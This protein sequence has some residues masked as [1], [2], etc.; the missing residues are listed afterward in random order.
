MR[1]KRKKPTAVIIKGNPIYIKGNPHAASFYRELADFLRSEGYKVKLDAGEPFTSPPKA[2]L[3]VGHSRGVDRLRFAPKGTITVALG[4]LDGIM[5][6]VDENYQRNIEKLISHFGS[7]EKMRSL[8]EKLAPPKEHY[9]LT[10]EMKRAIK[11]MK[12]RKRNP[13]ITRRGLVKAFTKLDSR[14]DVLSEGPDGQLYA[15]DLG[16]W[17]NM[18]LLDDM[19]L[20]GGEPTK[21]YDVEFDEKGILIQDDTGWNYVSDFGT[22]SLFANS[23]LE[24]QVEKIN[25]DKDGLGRSILEKAES[26]N[27]NRRAVRG[28]DKAIELIKEIAKKDKSKEMAKEWEEALFREDNPK[29]RRGD[30]IEAFRDLTAKGDV[31]SKGPGGFAHF[32]KDEFI[33]MELLGDM[34]VDPPDMDDLYD[35][36]FDRNG[37]YLGD[38]EGYGLSYFTSLGGTRSKMTDAAQMMLDHSIEAAVRSADEAGISLLQAVERLPFHHESM[39]GSYEFYES[40]RRVA[41]GRP[42]ESLAFMR[43]LVTKPW[44]QDPTGVRASILYSEARM[45]DGDDEQEGLFEYG[46]SHLP[47]PEDEREGNP[48]MKAKRA[49]DLLDLIDEEADTLLRARDG[50]AEMSFV[51]ALQDALDDMEGDV[52]VYAL[53]NAVVITELGNPSH[54]IG[55]VTDFDERLEQNTV[56]GTVL[57]EI[58]E[59]GHGLSPRIDY[60]VS[61]MH[62]PELIGLRSEPLSYETT[63]DIPFYDQDPAYLDIMGVTMNVPYSGDVIDTQ[64]MPLA[65]APAEVQE[66]YEE[67][68]GEID[69]DDLIREISSYDYPVRFSPENQPPGGLDALVEALAQ[70]VDT[71]TII[72]EVREIA[73]NPDVEWRINEQGYGMR[74]MPGIA[75]QLVRS[76]LDLIPDESQ[77]SQI[78]EYASRIIPGLDEED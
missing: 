21:V 23:L 53:N 56:D 31:L 75:S 76:S 51:E 57:E 39:P 11:S 32:D 43:G 47:F 29:V 59:P 45:L 49:A 71:D 68:F 27:M 60:V 12:K 15:F 36:Y 42:D 22:R 37:I 19:G 35:V 55:Y 64:T 50:G 20:D 34:D 24:D 7:R 69:L 17:I 77:R 14:G 72:A 40:I 66:A 70:E 48:R 28:T 6:P 78:R 44:M 38:P 33:R 61:R 26:I 73:A 62:S 18:E 3:W 52:D 63:D 5:H 1:K 8:L 9:I 4:T 54:V 41:G 25:E 65:E 10:S 46:L 58:V 16:E 30:L 67:Y 74:M 2:D 13:K